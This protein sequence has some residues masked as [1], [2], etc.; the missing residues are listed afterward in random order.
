MLLRA[1]AIRTVVPC[2]VSTNVCVESTLRDA[3]EHSYYVCVPQDACASWDMELHSAT[4]KTA[5][6]RFGLVLSTEEIAAVWQGSGARSAA[7]AQ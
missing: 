7:V 5:S 2:G 4:L 1:H 3:F 6:A